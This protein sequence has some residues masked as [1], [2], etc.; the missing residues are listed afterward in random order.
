M[1]ENVKKG[2]TVYYFKDIWEFMEEGVVRDPEIRNTV[3]G[4]AT[5]NPYN[6]PVISKID[7]KYYVG[8]DGKRTREDYGT[9]G[10]KLENCFLT[11]KEAWEERD[12]RIEEHKENLRKEITDVES[13]LKFPLNHEVRCGEYCDWYARGVYEEYIEKY[14]RGELKWS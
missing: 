14:K 3:I 12:H 10:A 13:L 6:I 7:W 11:A 1:I 4:S 5:P 8:A 9:S 2:M